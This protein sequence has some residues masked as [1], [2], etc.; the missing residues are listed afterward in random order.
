MAVAIG[1]ISLEEI[2]SSGDESPRLVASGEIVFLGDTV[3]ALVTFDVCSTLESVNS[4]VE[5]IASLLLIHAAPKTIR[6]KMLLRNRLFN[7]W[8]VLIIDFK[9]VNSDIKLSSLNYLCPA[10]K[11][12]VK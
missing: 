1:V 9:V 3:T 12:N 4:T 5:T 8:N 2:M 11:G 7:F 10:Y 6:M